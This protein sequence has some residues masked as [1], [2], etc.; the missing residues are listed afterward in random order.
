M[1]LILIVLLIA[2]VAF[3]TLAEAQQRGQAPAAGAAPA[4][5][6][7]G[8][9]RG[10]PPASTAPFNAKDF[11]GIWWKRGGSREYN[12]QRGQEPELTAAGKKAFDANR[13]GYGPRAVAPAT[14]NDPL[15]GCNPDGLLRSLLFNRPVEFIH[16]PNRLIQLFQYHGH[17]REAWID[18]RSLPKEIDLPR[19]YG[20]SV[21]RWEGDTLVIETVGLD[22][23][24]WVDN[25]GYPYSAEARL[26]E[27]YRRTAYDRIEMQIVLTDPVYY[28]KP[29][30]SEPKTWVLLTKPEEYAAPE[31]TALMEEL[32][33][34]L[35]EVDEFNTKIRNP[36]GGVKE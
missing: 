30:P 25:L 12:T 16:Q 22:D 11:S 35:D 10:L 3:S 19:F 20:Y 4:A 14:G 2:V 9:G 27:R 28:T 15:G 1:F 31:W 5:Q 8:G 23:R 34:P 6:G 26:E 33:V 18:G 32:C 17:R 24:E 36:A 21:G 13:P 7:G 29:W